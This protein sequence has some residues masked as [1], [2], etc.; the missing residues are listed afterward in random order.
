MHALD[1]EEQTVH[2]DGKWYSAKSVRGKILYDFTHM[3][4]LRN[5]TENTGEGKEK[6]K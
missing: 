6:I 3:W 2:T 1:T 5:K 4:N